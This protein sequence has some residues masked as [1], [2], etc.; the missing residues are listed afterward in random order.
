MSAKTI[1]SLEISY[2]NR[3]KFAVC[4]HEQDFKIWEV[5]CCFPFFKF[6][7]HTLESFHFNKIS[8]FYVKTLQKNQVSRFKQFLV[9][10]EGI[11]ELHGL[12]SSD[13]GLV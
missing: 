11:F 2:K 5:S 9:L 6:T 13:L 4:F 8:L 1:Q 7:N 10:A 12:E 3:G